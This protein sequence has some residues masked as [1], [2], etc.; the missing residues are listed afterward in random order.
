MSNRPRA[1]GR[2]VGPSGIAGLLAIEHDAERAAID[3]RRSHDQVH[4]ARVE[5]QGDAAAGPLRG[6]S[7]PRDGP[8]AGERP[9]V[10]AEIVG[11]SVRGAPVE[12]RAARRTEGRR[13]SIAEVRLTR[14]QLIP[15]GGCLRALALDVDQPSLEPLPARLRE[16]HLDHHLGALV[17]ALAEPVVPDPAFGVDEVERGPVVVRER[18]PDP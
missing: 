15:V 14:S 9:L 3:G 4:V 8:I 6:G 1:V 13:L 17:V 7:V 12:L 10:H 18:V 5:P 16:K 11:K 2:D